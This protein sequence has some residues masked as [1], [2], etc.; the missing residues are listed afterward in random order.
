MLEVCAHTRISTDVVIHD[1]EIEPM[2]NPRR[3][4]KRVKVCG[5]KEQS[6]RNA[7][8]FGVSNFQKAGNALTPRWMVHITCRLMKAADANNRS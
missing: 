8:A 1:P 5:R 3:E 2:R 4:F 6:G 7:G